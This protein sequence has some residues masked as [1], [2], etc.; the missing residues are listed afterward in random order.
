MVQFSVSVIHSHEQ[1]LF[2][3]TRSEARLQ[4]MVV[5]YNVKIKIQAQHESGGRS[6]LEV[7]LRNPRVHAK[8]D[9]KVSRHLARRR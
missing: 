9:G 6:L 4:E 5:S 1:V 7:A 3:E 8:A 2:G